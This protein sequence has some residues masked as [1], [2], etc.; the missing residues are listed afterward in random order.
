MQ[1]STAISV[2]GLTLIGL[3]IAD[4][5]LTRRLIEA[6]GRGVKE[7]N[8]LV[9]TDSVLSVFFSPAPVTVSIAFFAMFSLMVFY[10]E[11]TFSAYSD[12]GSSIKSMTAKAV[13]G[14]PFLI[15]AFVLLAVIQN[16][17]ILFLGA[18]VWP[19]AVREWKV[20]NPVLALFC[21]AMVL[22]LVFGPLFRKAMLALLINVKTA[23]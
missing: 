13:L 15:L 19:E 2:Y 16:S 14:M 18:S 1:K 20:A 22:E 21:L 23:P 12:R 5:I 4:A 7:L 17:S 6:H 11:Q 8:P 9:S 3:R 10:P